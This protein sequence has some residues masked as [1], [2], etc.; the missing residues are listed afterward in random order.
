MWKYATD[1]GR[2]QMKIWRIRTACWIRKATNT[3]SE[4]VML[5]AF[6]QQQWLYERA[7]ILR[8]TYIACFV[9]AVVSAVKICVPYRTT[10]SF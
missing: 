4:Y 6:P 10:A 5:I 1:P 2:T 7:S 3:R 8:Y 9:K